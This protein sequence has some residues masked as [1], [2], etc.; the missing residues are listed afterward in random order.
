MRGSEADW[1]A[2]AKHLQPNDLASTES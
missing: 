1:E 2:S